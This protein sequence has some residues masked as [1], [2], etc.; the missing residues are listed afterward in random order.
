MFIFISLLP[1]KASLIACFWR[2][3]IFSPFF[4]GFQQ[5][6]LP[7]LIFFSIY[8]FSFAIFSCFC[9]LLYNVAYYWLAILVC[10]VK[11][12]T[13]LFSSFV[14]FMKNKFY[15]CFRSNLSIYV[16]LFNK[17]WPTLG[18]FNS[19]RIVSNN[20]R[21]LFTNHIYNKITKKNITDSNKPRS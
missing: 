10:T 7:L 2:S 5:P 20:V 18:I 15:T 12:T 1:I 6:L 4:Y 17:I 8:Q 21:F 13:Y 14:Y 11:D 16:I 3:G 9:L 19:R